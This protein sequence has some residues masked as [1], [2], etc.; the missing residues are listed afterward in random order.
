MH[1]AVVQ[2]KPLYLLFFFFFFKRVPPNI[3]PPNQ[4]AFPAFW[5]VCFGNGRW[6]QMR[7]H[8]SY[9]Y[10]FWGSTFLFTDYIFYFIFSYCDDNFVS[11][12][13][14][15]LIISY[16]GDFFWRKWSFYMSVVMLMYCCTFI[17]PYMLSVFLA[18][19]RGYSIRQQAVRISVFF[20]HRRWSS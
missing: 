10:T 6:D 1:I 12:N 18:I 20:K 7:F 19:N 4:P 16:E 17:L 3:V 13:K 2:Q 11:P 15:L 8:V 5:E 14:R 9:I